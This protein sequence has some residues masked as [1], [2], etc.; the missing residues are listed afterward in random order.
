MGSDAW[1]Y[2]G[3]GDIAHGGAAG[4][5]V[6]FVTVNYRVATMGF[7]GGDAIRRA[8]GNPAGAAANWGIQD[9]VLA[10][11]WVKENVAAFGGNP[12][13][14]T[15]FGESAGGGSVSFHLTSPASWGLFH[16]AIVES[17]PVAPWL[18]IPFSF[19][20]A[21][22]ANR[23][24][25]AGCAGK[26]DPVSCLR[27]L[28]WQW[29]TDREHGA[30]D[31]HFDPTVDGVSIPRSPLTSLEL[32]K[33]APGVPVLL[34]TNRDEGTIF[35]KQSLN[36]TDA[37]YRAFLREEA[38]GNATLADAAYGLWP[39]SRFPA[40]AH[41]SSAWQALSRLH[42]DRSMTCP[43]RMTAKAL[44][45]AHRKQALAS[46]IDSAAVPGVYTYLYTHVNSVLHALF[47][48]VGVCHMSELL[49]VWVVREFLLGPG[50]AALAQTFVALWTNFAH[51]GD[52]SSGAADVPHWAPFTK[53][54]ASQGGG[55]TDTTLVLDISAS[56]P[57]G[58]N[59]ANVRQPECDFWAAVPW[60]KWHSDPK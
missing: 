40:T 54:P 46:R 34:G 14:V 43:N 21:T 3:A 27:A 4:R 23:T 45:A 32:G 22:L 10:L 6:V 53:F 48:W 24:Q 11:R 19:A 37:E 52:P 20:E 30:M 56:G 12:N 25:E 29:F 44:V 31:H 5:S 7:M 8:N 39:S 57:T 35:N 49:N 26:A 58:V 42:G 33:V 1:Y 60:S 9:Q 59:T 51:T 55:G 13:S 15:I 2:D 50:E 36:L 18:T 16:R 41:A 47:P 38:M 28:P 17:G